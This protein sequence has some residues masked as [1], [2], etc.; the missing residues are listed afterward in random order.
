MRCA[1]EIRSAQ[2]WAWALPLGKVSASKRRSGNKNSLDGF[3]AWRLGPTY[4]DFVD[5][6]GVSPA[7]LI[8]QQELLASNPDSEV[9]EADRRKINILFFSLDRF[10][11]LG[12][13]DLMSLCESHLWRPVYRDDVS[14]VLL[15]NRP[16]NRPWIERH[17]LSCQ[18]HDFG[19]P[20][21]GSRVAQ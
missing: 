12:T 21:P 18:T 16:E 10:A 13:P 2:I 9:W 17:E 6:R 19:A 15:R 3:T 1:T 7:V 5:G 11:G 8:E 20:P 14:M 4:A